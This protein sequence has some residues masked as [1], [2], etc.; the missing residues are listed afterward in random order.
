M[1]PILQLE[2]VTRKFGGLTA[3]DDVS[4]QIQPR[5]RSWA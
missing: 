4:F 5:E 3:L 1:N 2:N